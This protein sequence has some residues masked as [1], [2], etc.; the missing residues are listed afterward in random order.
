MNFVRKH[1]LKRF[2]FQ[3]GRLKKSEE[4]ES[5]LF[6]ERLSLDPILHLVRSPT[7]GASDLESLLLADNGLYL[8]Y[9]RGGWRRVAPRIPSMVSK[10]VIHGQETIYGSLVR[11]Q[12]MSII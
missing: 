7:S 1:V 11:E 6:K 12:F 3:V 4:L 8:W 9:P 2:P 5:K 10:A